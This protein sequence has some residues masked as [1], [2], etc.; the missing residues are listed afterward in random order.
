MERRFNATAVTF[1]LAGLIA[2]S[3]VVFLVRKLPGERDLRTGTQQ[4]ADEERVS[5]EPARETTTAPD[6]KTPPAAGQPKQAPTKPKDLLEAFKDAAQNN[7]ADAVQRLLGDAKLDDEARAQLKSLF[8]GAKIKAVREVGEI[9]L[10]KRSR[11][12][13][14]FDEAAGA[15]LLFDFVN[16]GGR[17]K[18]ENVRLSNSAKK[19]SAPVDALDLA[20]EFIQ[21]T[22]RQDFERARA[23]VDPAT[24]SDA[25]IA[26]LCI[27]FEEG[28]YRMRPERPLRAMFQRGDRSGYLAYV[29]AADGSA[30]AEFAVNLAKVNAAPGW[31]ISEINV[32]QL[33]A[34]YARRFA[35]GDVY[36]SPLIK[37]PNGGDTLVLYFDFN[38]DVV[39][40]R[41]Q[42]QLEIVG[43]VLKG[44]AKKKL[45]LS[46]HTDAIG[47]DNFNLGLSER[48]AEVVRKFLIEHG[49]AEAQIVTQAK[50]ASMPRRP[51]TTATGTDDPE[52]RRA[53]R[54]TEIYLDF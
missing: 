43:R 54:R 23:M 51:N 17:W 35:G 6:I 50:G 14:E 29:E 49:V 52:G 27:L 16:D 34:D 45:T 8:A 25:K 47:G 40:P 7:D 24:V 28:T 4:T 9:E 36:Y 12:A 18:I 10:N 26:G 20:D 19:Q 22:L 41:T 11:W 42:R 30:S 3:A 44:D 53:N 33:L 13:I 32:D 15:Q 21:A 1:A 46:G 48:R 2:L 38:E 5:D 31:K 37:N 39:S